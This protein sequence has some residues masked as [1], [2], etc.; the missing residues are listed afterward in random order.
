MGTC[1]AGRCS[2]LVFRY[3]LLFIISEDILGCKGHMPGL[4][5]AGVPQ[6][7]CC[8]DTFTAVDGEGWRGQ[9]LK[10]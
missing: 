4:F 6:C 9:Q 5:M 2:R 7:C 10:S 8:W 3:W 1:Q